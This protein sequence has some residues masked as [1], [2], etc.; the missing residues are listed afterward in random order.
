MLLAFVY[1]LNVIQYIRELGE[2]HKSLRT[3]SPNSW[4]SASST[5]AYTYDFA[6][7]HVRRR[8]HHQ[9]GSPMLEPAAVL[10]RLVESRSES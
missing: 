9:Y 5:V 8:N 6:I 10:M 1:P 3:N 4:Y 2:P 7:H